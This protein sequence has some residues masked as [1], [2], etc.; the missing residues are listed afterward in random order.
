[1]LVSSLAAFS[2]LVRSFWPC[3]V[4]SSY[5]RTLLPV[6]IL[7]FPKSSCLWWLVGD[8]FIARISVSEKILTCSCVW[9]PTIVAWYILLPLLLRILKNSTSFISYDKQNMTPLR[10]SFLLSTCVTWTTLLWVLAPPSSRCLT[11]TPTASF[12]LVSAVP[13]AKWLLG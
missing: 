10:P 4:P 5:I 3:K 1:M 9:W 8:S 11:N 7:A 6:W 2:G 13:V 12:V